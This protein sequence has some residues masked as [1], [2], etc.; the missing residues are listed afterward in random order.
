MFILPST[1]RCTHYATIPAIFIILTLL[2]PNASSKLNLISTQ[3]DPSISQGG[4]RSLASTISPDGRNLVYLSLRENNE[5]GLG[6]YSV[7]TIGGKDPKELTSGNMEGIEFKISPDSRWVVFKAKVGGFIRLFSM[8]INGS[9]SPIELTGLE[10]QKVD[11]K[12]F[13]GGE[14]Y[15]SEDSKLV[16]YSY[17]GLT[18]AVPGDSL[19]IRSIEG[20]SRTIE[21]EITQALRNDP[22]LV[23]NFRL[24]A[25]DFLPGSASVYA[26]YRGDTDNKDRPQRLLIYSV[27]FDSDPEIIYALPHSTDLFQLTDDAESIIFIDLNPNG[28][29]NQLFVE[30]VAIENRNRRLLSSQQDDVKRIV[31]VSE[32]W[33]LY[34]RSETEI[35][36]AKD[37]K[38]D[39]IFSIE[40][41][42]LSNINQPTLNHQI[43]A[44]I[45]FP[46]LKKIVRSQQKLIYTSII[47]NNDEGTAGTIKL[48]SEPLQGASTE[49]P[50][51][52]LA[53]EP[54]EQVF[55]GATVPEHVISPDERWVIQ[56][57]LNSQTDQPKQQ[58]WI[59]L[60]NQDISIDTNLSKPLLMFSP[61]SDRL[62]VNAADDSSLDDIV[63][64]LGYDALRTEDGTESINSSVTALPDNCRALISK[65]GLPTRILVSD[66]DRPLT[67]LW[68]NPSFSGQG[69]STQQ[70]GDRILAT[71]FVYDKNGEPLWLD[72]SEK[73]VNNQLTAPLLRFI[74]PE[75][76]VA[77]DQSKIN[78]EQLGTATLTLGDD[79]L[80]A[81]LQYSV[82]GV[83]S[84]IQLQPFFDGPANLYNGYWWDPET[85]GR[86][87]RL[88]RKN[89]D[90]FGIAFLYD[91]SGNDTWF[92]FQGQLISDQFEGKLS[93]FTGPKLG[94]LWDTGLVQHQEVGNVSLKFNAN[95]RINA[96][97]EVNGLNFDWNLQP[98]RF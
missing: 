43:N 23:S 20:Q 98:F 7:S 61:V 42:S 93:R 70:R 13:S 47:A 9:G 78:S 79:K 16:V 82:G 65:P 85:S 63:S 4:L 91:Q 19:F 49:N 80:S 1:V 46:T 69:V 57:N 96:Q 24:T 52:Q 11:L 3:N 6:L 27:A 83:A 38:L 29:N 41:Y 22:L 39:S 40:P 94:E 62:L 73:L 44:K 92:T 59:S 18:T 54:W 64:K 87:V 75:I 53:E 95:G 58:R 33:V 17:P 68:W 31:E 21:I 48:M 86:G 12:T 55:L 97:F 5:S 14:F 89:N 88:Y 90:L 60:E 37:A 26:T 35:L 45:G 8:S 28:Q 67:E 71:W 81:T 51:V 84:T 32:P 56:T 36:S 50:A 15:I 25:F 76:G 34:T 74:G 30:D 77:W 66:C 72:F 10:A 2:S